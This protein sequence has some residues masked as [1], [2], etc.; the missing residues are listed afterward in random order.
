MCFPPGDLPYSNID[1]PFCLIILSDTKI[2]SFMPSFTKKKES[3]PKT[4]F[5]YIWPAKCIRIIYQPASIEDIKNCGACTLSDW[6]HHAVRMGERFSI[7]FLKFQSCILQ[8]ATF[9]ETH[10][11]SAY[12]S[13]LMDSLS[14]KYINTEQL[15][16]DGEWN[17]LIFLIISF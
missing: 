9:L 8:W 14:P 12:F 2:Y 15:Q 5:C 13:L 16:I 17:F 3:W 1:R 11:V 10:F 6:P 4:L 7:F